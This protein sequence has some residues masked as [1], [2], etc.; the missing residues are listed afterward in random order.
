MPKIKKLLFEKGI[1]QNTLAIAIGID[2][3]TISKYA[4]YKTFPTRQQLIDMVGFLNCTIDDLYFSDELPIADNFIKLQEVASALNKEFK[5][6]VKRP[7]S[8][9]RKKVQTELD[10]GIWAD[11]LSSE[12]LKEMGCESICEFIRIAILEKIQRHKNR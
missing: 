4:N 9:R 7:S 6:Y 1:N 10:I 2:E 11:Y 3:A 8:R 5:K 12:Q